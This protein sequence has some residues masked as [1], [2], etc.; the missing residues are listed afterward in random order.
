VGFFALIKEWLEFNAKGR[1]RRVARPY[2]T[3]H[4]IYHCPQCK[5]HYIQMESSG[6]FECY[7]CGRDSTE[8]EAKKASESSST[9]EK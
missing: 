3:P 8:E 1:G 5:S 7:D 4:P 2:I 9:V 6:S